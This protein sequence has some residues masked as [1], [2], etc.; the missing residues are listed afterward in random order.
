MNEVPLPDT[1][2]VRR[3]ELQLPGPAER[4]ALLT[5]YGAAACPA[6]NAFR[7]P[8]ELVLAAECAAELG[9]GP[10]GPGWCRPCG[11]HMMN[12]PAT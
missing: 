8:L 5:S 2:N 9:S 3:V 11:C 1:S 6:A 7:T 10:T 4:Q 12:C